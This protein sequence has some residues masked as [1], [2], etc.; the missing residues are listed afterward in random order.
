M[1][2]CIALKILN[3]ICNFLNKKFSRYFFSSCLPT[4]LTITIKL[5]KQYYLFDNCNYHDSSIINLIT[6]ITVTVVINL[7]TL[8][9]LTM[10][11]LI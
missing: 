9:I 10:V 7:I 4:K 11:L 6:V 5:V 8:I 1:L 2:Y 3:E